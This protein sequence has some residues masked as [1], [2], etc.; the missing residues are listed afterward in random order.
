MTVKEL[1][2]QLLD[3]DMDKRISIA[4]DVGFENEYGKCNGS[5]YDIKSIEEKHNVYLNFDNRN[6]RLKGNKPDR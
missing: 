4:D 3:C 6:H 1:I 2:I 5:A